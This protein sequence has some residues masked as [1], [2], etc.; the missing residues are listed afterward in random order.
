MYVLWFKG[1]NLFS[2]SFCLKESIEQ[3]EKDIA[4]NQKT[5]AERQVFDLACVCT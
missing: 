4:E 2:I 5:F 1:S 3:L